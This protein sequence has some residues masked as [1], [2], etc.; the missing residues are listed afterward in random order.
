MNKIVKYMMHRNSEGNLITPYFISDG[1]YFPVGNEYVGVT[2]DDDEVYIP[3]TLTVLSEQDFKDFVV[4]LVLRNNEDELLNDENKLELA[5]NWL[6][7]NF[8]VI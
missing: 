3:E 1:G 6:S 5:N 7:N 2:V 8:E 4:G